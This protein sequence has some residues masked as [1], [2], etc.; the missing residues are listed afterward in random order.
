M[1]E[2]PRQQ[3]EY[4]EYTEEAAPSRRSAPDR[5]GALRA[6]G[7]VAAALVWLA[8]GGSEGFPPT[9]AGSRRSRTLMAIWWMTEAIP[10][11]ATSLLP[12]VLIPALTERTVGAG[13]RPLS[14]ARSSS[15][16]SAA[17]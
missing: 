6:A 3:G 12:I 15:C 8:L 11:A 1:T 5:S 9:R 13:D 16:F 7:L 17:S 10:L 4:E 2:A 14:Q